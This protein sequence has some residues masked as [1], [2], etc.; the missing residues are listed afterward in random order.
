MT[1]SQITV[2]L[3]DGD[4]TFTVQ[5][6]NRQAWADLVLAHPSTE[7]RWRYDEDTLHPA[8]LV[9]CV[10]DPVLD[11]D[12]AEQLADDTDIGGPLLTLCLQLSDPGSWEWASRRLA[13]DGRLA[14]EVGAA[15]RM[16]IPHAQFTAW[17]ATSQDLALAW[18]EST[19]RVCPGCGV[20]EA[21]MR[22]R[23]AWDT[24]VV[25]CVHCDLLKTTRDQIDEKNTH[26]EHAVLVRP[27][28]A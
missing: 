14:A 28:V 5:G 15:V 22:D 17:P 13:T 3:D 24:D 9:A 12:L 7:R 4:V 2:Q 20:P 25:G 26:R 16:G 23:L 19:Q 27:E 6:L 21:D 11:A 10:T 18:I 8:L 1:G